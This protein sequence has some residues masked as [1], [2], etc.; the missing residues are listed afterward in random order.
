M[1][2]THA[3]SSDFHTQNHEPQTVTRKRSRD[4][5][6]A[7]PLLQAICL[8]I[9]LAAILTAAAAIAGSEAKDT[10]T[11]GTTIPALTQPLPSEVSK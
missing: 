10:T 2:D 9:F 5:Q 4:L 7:R 11:P 8:G 6:D 1:T 3:K